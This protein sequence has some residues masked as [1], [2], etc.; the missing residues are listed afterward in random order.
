M[1]Y[2][3]VES[4]RSPEQLTRAVLQVSEML[5]MYR[6]E[7]ARVLGL[8]CGDIGTLLNDKQYLK[9]D[10]EAWQ[11]AR[12]FIDFYQILYKRMDGKEP[13]ICHWLRSDNADLKGVPLLLMV[14]DGQLPRVRQYLLKQTRSSQ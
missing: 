1:H 5:G 8:Q 14:D 13:E 11:Q 3:S 12:S 2:I 7:L 9:P 10:T 6:A 4:C